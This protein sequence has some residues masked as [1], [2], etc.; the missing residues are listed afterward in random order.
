MIVSSSNSSAPSALQGV[1]LLN[2]GLRVPQD[3]R[4][5][6]A[7]SDLLQ[8]SDF[9]SAPATTAKAGLAAARDR[10]LSRGDAAVRR[11]AQSS[12]GVKASES[13]APQYALIS[14]AGQGSGSSL[15]ESP[16]L[17]RDPRLDDPVELA[18]EAAAI[19]LATS[20]LAK[21]PEP[22]LA[23]APVEEF[24]QYAGS[25]LGGGTGGEG[26]SSED[27]QAG[28]PAPLPPPAEEAAPSVEP[29]APAETVSR[30]FRIFGHS[31]DMPR[32]TEARTAL[33]PVAP[34]VEA[35]PKVVTA[36]V[37]TATESQA[38]ALAGNG[39][40]ILSAQ[41]SVLVEGSVSDQGS[42]LSQKYPLA[43]LP[44]E[45]SNPAVASLETRVSVDP[46]DAV[47]LEAGLDRGP[48]QSAQ[49]AEQVS[50]KA[51]SDTEFLSSA[52]P[53][54]PAAA[55]FAAQA[56]RSGAQAS[57]ESAADEARGGKQ[58]G[59]SL[60]LELLSD[61]DVGSPNALRLDEQ[62]QGSNSGSNH[63]NPFETHEAE[64]T[65][66]SQRLF[67]QDQ[68]EF[69]TFSAEDVTV[70]R[71]ASPTF[72]RTAES[73]TPSSGRSH[74]SSPLTSAPAD[75][76]PLSTGPSSLVVESGKVSHA[77]GSRPTVLPPVN[78]RS[79]ELFDVVQRALER[80]RSEN[81]SHLAVEVTLDDGS[82]FGLEVRLG[83]SGLQAAFRS[84]SQPLLKV[85]ENGWA[86][87][88]AKETAESRVVSAAFEGRSGF[89]EFS[90][91]GSN[92][93]E[94]RQQFEDNSAAA[95]LAASDVKSSPARAALGEAETKLHSPEGG[96]AVYA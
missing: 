39:S 20:L 65:Q 36:V 92:A 61:A 11:D 44:S 35:E 62:G 69:G 49:G 41:N 83:A 42:G 33:A 74:E 87:F 6:A 68:A 3:D 55:F 29:Q 77:D 75:F 17:P 71:E 4:D 38:A 19:A 79:T 52:V 88:L 10:S 22:S 60:N 7:F 51:D 72:E 18:L 67:A 27:V 57:A 43:S 25:E 23:P 85:L 84:E 2:R 14:E 47:K 26:G 30:K 16:Q 12:D 34:R 40:N 95:R 78:A 9:A 46:P 56:E 86:G 59:Q 21:P 64:E 1:D 91:N 63:S 32:S 94:R 70:S 31:S 37:L 96:V 93:G 28:K 66:H 53:V 50:S 15:D 80:A 24:S 81:P 8:A 73:S 58:T 54:N 48:Q 76:V 13:T 90:N 45:N 5:P 82:S 89:G